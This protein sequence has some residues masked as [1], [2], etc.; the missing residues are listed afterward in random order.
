M[1]APRLGACCPLVVYISAYGGGAV[2][3]LEFEHTL[4][5]ERT[6]SIQPP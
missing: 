4:E 6:S 3:V 5:Y 2:W 1:S